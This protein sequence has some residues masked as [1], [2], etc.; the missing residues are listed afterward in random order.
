MLVGACDCKRGRNGVQVWE[1]CVQAGLRVWGRVGGCL[2]W[3]ACS[4]LQPLVIQ[5]QPAV[6]SDPLLL[7]FHHSQLVWQQPA[8]VAL[9]YVSCIAFTLLRPHPRSVTTGH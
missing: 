4:H 5:C 6:W 1:V 8:A 7:Q 9:A 2:T 3:T